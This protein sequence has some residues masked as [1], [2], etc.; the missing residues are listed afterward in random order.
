VAQSALQQR[1]DKNRDVFAQRQQEL[2]QDLAQAL[3]ST[4]EHAKLLAEL[5][6]AFLLD[7]EA[8]DRQDGT[9]N[10]WSGGR[11]VLLALV[12]LIPLTSLWIYRDWGAGADLALPEI[13]A[14][15]RSADSEEAQIA[16]L[17]ELADFLQNRFERRPDDLQNGYMLGTLNLELDRYDAAIAAFRSMLEQMESGPDRA[18]VLG[19]LA[20]AQYMRADSQV[21]EEVRATI[22]QTLALNP[23]ES[24]VM[25]ILAIDAF[26]REDFA[27]AVVYWRR[28]LAAAAPGSPQEQSLR[29]RIA[30]VEAYLP[31]TAEAMPVAAATSGP[32]ITLA[33]DLAPELAASITPDMRLFI[34]VRNPAMPMPILAQNLAVPVFPFTINLDNS[35]SMMGLTLESAPNLVVGARLSAS[36]TAQ[37]GDLQTLSEPFVLSEL[38]APLT[39]V[40][41]QVVP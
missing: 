33:V 3:V 4:E 36:A 37:P 35:M 20:Q 40:I 41:D 30:M 1:R 9:R 11:Q 14:Q 12:L 32:V 24:S 17:A 25:S 7:M 18:T 34:Y 10:N 27:S 19:Q 38:A 29:E 21:T 23:N 13:L 15:L 8:L 2:E 26:L 16:V 31:E 39:L 22:D 28:Q 6:R 5:Q